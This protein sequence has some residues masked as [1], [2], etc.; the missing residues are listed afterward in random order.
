MSKL[1]A[2]STADN[3]MLF[4]PPPLLE[5]DDPAAYNEL[6]ARISGTVKPADVLEESGTLST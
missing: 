3:S 5:G 1:L 2:S 6:L 4:G